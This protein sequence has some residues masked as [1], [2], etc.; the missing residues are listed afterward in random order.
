MFKTEICAQEHI[1]QLKILIELLIQSRHKGFS[2]NLHLHGSTK[3]H[4]D[5]TEVTGVLGDV[6]R[7]QKEGTDMAKITE[8]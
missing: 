5:S 7:R 8:D 2:S 4:T 6:Q 3:S 1:E